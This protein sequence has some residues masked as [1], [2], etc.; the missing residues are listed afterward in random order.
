VVYSRDPDGLNTGD[1]IDVFYRRSTDNGA[2]W[3]A[4]Q[5]LGVYSV[6]P[7]L[8]LMHNGVLACSFGRPTVNVMFSLDGCGREWTAPTTVFTGNSTCYTGLREVAPGRLLLVYDSNSEGRPWDA[9]DNQIN[10]VF[11]DVG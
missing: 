8:C 7:E 1:V 9:R 4:P 5:D 11:V 2:T 3:S 10:A 6:D